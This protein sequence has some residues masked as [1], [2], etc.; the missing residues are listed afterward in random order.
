M[1]DFSDADIIGSVHLDFD[2]Y[3]THARAADCAVCVCV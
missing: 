3:P 2:S 1:N